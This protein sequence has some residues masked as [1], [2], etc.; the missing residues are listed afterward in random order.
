MKSQKQ[1]ALIFC[2][3]IK[4]KNFLAVTKNITCKSKAVPL[5]SRNTAVNNYI[6]GLIQLTDSFYLSHSWKGMTLVQSRYTYILKRSKIFFCIQLNI[7]LNVSTILFD[8][9]SN[10]IVFIP[11]T[12]TYSFWAR[13]NIKDSRK[14]HAQIHVDMK[15][16]R[17][18]NE[19]VDRRWM[20]RNCN[21]ERPFALKVFIIFFSLM[22][23]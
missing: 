6:V 19:G 3:L 15:Q 5:I 7:K 21:V 18:E 22:R 13:S 10:K 4:D 8:F 14:I 9:Y 1:L 17:Y 20:V 16:P 12:L 2:N 23:R 11:S